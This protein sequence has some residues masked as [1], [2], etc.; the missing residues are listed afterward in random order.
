MTIADPRTQS[1]LVDGL[2]RRARDL[3]ISLTQACNLRCHYCMPA[4]G[5]AIIPR[6]ELLSADEVARLVD[7]AVDHLGI[8][9]IRL[10]GGEPLIRRDL[11]AIVAAIRT[12]HPDVP[13]AL[14]TNG[15]GLARR[16]KGLAAAGLSRV[17]ISMDTVDRELF[18]AI[19]RRDRLTDVIAGVDAA[20][21]AGLAP[22]KINAVALQQNLVRAPELLRWCLDRGL[23]LRFIE[24]MPLDADGTWDRDTYVTA[25]SLLA[26][27][28]E[29]FELTAVGRE[30]AGAPAELWR[31]DG[32]P[33]T[34][35]V[36]AS[37]S[38]SFCGAC[39][40]TR[41]T[42]EGRVRPCLFSD[43]EIDLRSILRSG[44]D[45]AALVAA[46]REVTWRKSPG[47]LPADIL[48]HP[49]RPMGAIGG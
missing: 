2:G 34:V 8:D 33:G 17:N 16:A 29:H 36:I 31:V 35:G 38:R 48:T 21:A 9:E 44:G 3:R 4:E 12:A 43:D 19:T 7:V 40:R 18:A 47:H 20:L 37:M 6:E 42:A 45:D 25:A 1:V 30:D 46:W 49:R 27:L 22:V 41:I 32:G 14:T 15:L 10:T 28:G 11:E 26:V 24:A 5:L 23:A 13:I 39:D